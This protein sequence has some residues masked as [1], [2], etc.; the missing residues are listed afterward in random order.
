MA[1]P[2]KLAERIE[3]TVAFGPEGTMWVAEGQERF[4]AVPKPGGVRRVPLVDAAG[5]VPCTDHTGS[6]ATLLADADGDGVSELFVVWTFSTG[7]GQMGAVDQI[8]ICGW[9]WDAPGVKPLDAGLLSELSAL[10]LGEPEALQR[11]LDARRASPEGWTALDVD[12]SER[13]DVRTRMF[14]A[15]HHA[16]V[17]RQTGLYSVELRGRAMG[18]DGPVAASWFGLEEIGGGQRPWDFDGVWKPI[19]RDGEAACCAFDLSADESPHLDSAWESGGVL[20]AVMR[21]GQVESAPDCMVVRVV[22]EGAGPHDQSCEDFLAARGT[23]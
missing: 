16:L 18:K 9:S 3:E 17:V 11:H 22:E 1:P 12:E 7:A 23:P 21:Q 5:A 4:L 2:P 13:P 8:E 15:G 19:D 20:Y 14:K 6:S 10:A